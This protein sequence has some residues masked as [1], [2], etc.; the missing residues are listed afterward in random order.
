[1]KFVFS[2]LFFA[3]AALAANCYKSDQSKISSV[4][5]I[6]CFRSLTVLESVTGRE[7][8]F[9]GGILDGTHKVIQETELAPPI[10]QLTIKKNL[11]NP[12]QSHCEEGDLA[13]LVVTVNYDTQQEIL[14]EPP[15][16]EAESQKSSDTCHSTPLKELIHFD[17]IDRLKPAVI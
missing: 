9:T 10:V 4:P 2:I 6:I 5:S 16:M 11:T 3:N 17:L 13:E 14:T 1:M 12:S 7:L 8:R 15:R